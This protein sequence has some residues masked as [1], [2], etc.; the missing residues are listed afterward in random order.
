MS[1]VHGSFEGEK[2]VSEQMPIS[3]R[4]QLSLIHI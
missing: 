4:M 1:E 2:K 3:Q